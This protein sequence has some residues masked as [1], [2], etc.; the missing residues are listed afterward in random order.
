MR[1]NLVAKLKGMFSTQSNNEGGDWFDR[2]TQ[3]RRDINAFEEEFI[4]PL[5]KQFKNTLNTK[6]R[7][8]QLKQIDDLKAHVERWREMASHMHREAAT[9]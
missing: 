1:F 9:K 5:W 8:A 4:E 6:Q 7:T 2:L 3:E